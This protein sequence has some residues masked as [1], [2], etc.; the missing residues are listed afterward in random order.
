MSNTVI[1]WTQISSIVGFIGALFV[2]YRVLVGTKDATIELL[3][4]KISSLETQLEEAHSSSPDVLAERY[5]RRVKLLSEELERLSKDQ[6]KNEEEI[7]KKENELEE[8]KDKLSQL[9]E[10]L[11]RAQ[12]LMGE[13]FCPHCKAPM[14]VRDYHSELVEYGG[15]ELDVDH[16][17]IEF[18][19]GFALADNQIRG[20][21]RNHVKEQQST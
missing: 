2:L 15:R 11:E 19:C 9:E 12:E 1:F 14:L 8:A 17:Y 3:R 16:E 4:E 21:C 7:G 10:Q 6:D 13:F 5:S 20:E 18:E